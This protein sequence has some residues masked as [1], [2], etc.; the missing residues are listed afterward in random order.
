MN[1]TYI[2]AFKAGS[3]GRLIANIIWGLTKNI[4]YDYTLTDFN[5]T[6]N[7]TPY[8]VSFD[9][10]AMPAGNRIYSDSKIYA[11]FTFTGSPGVI[12]VHAY[13]DFDTIR[14][15]FPDAKVV[16]VSYTNNN[17]DE[18]TGNSLL[19]NGFEKLLRNSGESCNDTR[20]I[21]TVYKSMFEE[22]YTGQYIQESYR[23]DIFNRYKS[24]VWNEFYNSE[25]V[26]PQV[27]I[28]FIDKTLILEYTEMYTDMQSVL[29]KISSFTGAAIQDNIVQLY[30]NY[31]AGRQQLI[32]SHMPWLDK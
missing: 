16:L 14:S 13:P 6:H 32:H 12:T 2:V 24:R 3:S 22:D 26:N 10:S 4:N 8:A 31:L 9:I 29:D 19:K 25:F 27:P 18:I 30:K 28:D 7:F 23:H 15:R 20:F 21:T 1:D 11:Y 5:S 17:I